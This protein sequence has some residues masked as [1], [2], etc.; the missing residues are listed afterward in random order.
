MDFQLLFVSEYVRKNQYFVS[1]FLYYFCNMSQDY[2]DFPYH[3]ISKI[4]LALLHLSQYS[5]MVQSVI[6]VA[7][8]HTPLYMFKR[9]A[10]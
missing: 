7:A 2:V 3:D 5:G 4:L 10:V 1:L 9:N 6:M 8:C